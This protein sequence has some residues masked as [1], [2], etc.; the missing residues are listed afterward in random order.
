MVT[1]P[2]S[3]SIHGSLARY[4]GGVHHNDTENVL[5]GDVHRGDLG[6]TTVLGGA[7]NG[8]VRTE[9]ENSEETGAGSLTTLGA[10]RV[11]GGCDRGGQR[12]RSE[13]EGT[14]NGQ[15]EGT[16]E[17]H[18]CYWFNG[19]ERNNR[20]RTSFRPLIVCRTNLKMI[21]RTVPGSFAAI[22]RCSFLTKRAAMR[23][24]RALAGRKTPSAH[25]QELI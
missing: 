1:V 15:G 6:D 21:L 17:L 16:Y 22:H 19:T 3:C 9:A 14:H 2:A 12:A 25:Y 8:S 7:L 10:Y 4:R 13:K 20:Q 5:R 11:A 18:F 23:G 24:F